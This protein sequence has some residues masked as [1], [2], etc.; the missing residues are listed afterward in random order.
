M[1]DFLLNVG[2]FTFVIILV[3][4]VVFISSVVSLFYKWILSKK[5]IIFPRVISIIFAVVFS[6]FIIISLWGAHL[7]LK[8]I[9]STP[10]IV[11]VTSNIK[12]G[13]EA[14]LY[15]KGKPKEIYSVTINDY[16]DDDIID[17]KKTDSDGLAVFEW[18]ITYSAEPG[19]YTIVIQDSELEEVASTEF[20]IVQ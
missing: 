15:F 12:I 1:R 11:N 13:D 16:F 3:V 14:H 6:V 2:S 4:I 19:T 10:R 18:L 8:Q 7:Q 9:T 5:S 17:E 20:V